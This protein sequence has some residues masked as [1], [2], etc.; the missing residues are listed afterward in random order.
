M[1]QYNDALKTILDYGSW[2]MNKRTGKNCLSFPG[3][4]MRFDLTKGFP[5]ITTKKLAWNAVKGELIA[6]LNGATNAKDF[7][8]LNCNIWDQNANDPGSPD[9]PNLWLTNPFRKGEDDL[10]TIYGSQWRNW[11]SFKLVPTEDWSDEIHKKML[12]EG[13]SYEDTHTGV[14]Y[15]KATDQIAECITKIICTP[16]D[17]RI[18]F[19]AW[20][21]A[22]LS[23]MALPPC[24]LLYQFL[25]NPTTKELSLCM[26]QRSADYFLGVP[27]N[28][29]SSALLL[30]IV[31]RLTG[32]KA[33][34]LSLTTN[35]SHIYENH[36]DQVREQLTRTDF[37]LPTLGIKNWQY[38]DTDALMSFEQIRTMARMSDGGVG[39]FNPDEIM[40]TM[41]DFAGKQLVTLKPE[42]FTLEGYQ[43]HAAI[44]ADMAV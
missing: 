36:M 24:H 34:W 33:K 11:P 16:S 3:L 12:R 13:W 23:S 15:R 32:Y 39:E 4:T 22:E 21:P 37:P 30:E 42:W 18:L 26:T 35:D 7:R 41:A 9:A 31:A 6:F 2:I 10:G 29:A 8:A 5:A 27:F 20:N 38:G 28:I 25:P 44:K 1:Q 14:L 19:H 40:R 43:S 17:R